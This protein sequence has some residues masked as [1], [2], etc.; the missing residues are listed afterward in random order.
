MIDV[1]WCMAVE[2]LSI[3]NP[4]WWNIGSSPQTLSIR[5]Y[6]IVAYI[7]WFPFAASWAFTQ[8]FNN[9]EWY[10]HS[11]LI[12]LM[13]LVIRQY[14]SNPSVSQIFVL[15]RTPLS[16]RQEFYHRHGIYVSLALI[17][18]NVRCPPFEK[19]NFN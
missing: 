18:R 7:L 6:I 19:Y 10:Q 2:L 1:I 5:F 13:S 17:S 9:F 14:N 3:N 4:L 8:S 15:I 11:V 16:E 12:R